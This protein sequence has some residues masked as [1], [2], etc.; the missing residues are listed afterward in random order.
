MFRVVPQCSAHIEDKKM[1]KDRLRK[2]RTIFN[3]NGNQ[4]ITTVANN[5]GLS[6]SMIS[7]IENGNSSR[8]VGCS[9]ICILSK[10]YG[11]SSDW[12]LGLSDIPNQNIGVAREY[13][14][15][16][17]E[18]EKRLSNLAE[19]LSNVSEEIREVLNATP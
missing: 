14:L 6:K 17:A 12:L 13:Y 16:A 18:K 8:D 2:A 7:D 11:V 5:T 1:I 4:S 19:L 10:Y 9:Y 15:K 3:V